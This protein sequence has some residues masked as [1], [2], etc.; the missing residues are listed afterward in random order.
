MSPPQTTADKDNDSNKL[1]DLSSFLAPAKIPLNFLIR[2]STSRE[3]WNSKGDI[4]RVEASDVGLP[5]DLSRILSYEPR[6]V[7]IINRLPDA[8]LKTSDQLYEVDE[9]IADLTRKRHAPDDQTRWKNWALI[10][11]YRSIPWKYLEP[12]SHDPTLAF[13]HLKHTLEA[14]QDGFPGLSNAAKIDLGLTLIES[15]RFSDMAWK[16]YAVNQAKRVSVGVENQY[17]ASRIA[18]AECVLNRIEGSMLRSAANLTPRSSE[19]TAPDVRMHCI[20]GQYAIQR[21]LNFMQ[22]EALESAE[23]V[24]ETWSPLNET[25]FPMEQAVN[26]R[27]T[28]IR[29]RSLRQRGELRD[30]IMQL[31]AGRRLKD[32]P[33]DIVLG[34]DLRDLICELADGLRDYNFTGAAEN[35]VRW[36]MERRRGSYIP[37][38]GKNL[39]ELSLAEVAFS[40]GQYYNSEMLCLGALKEF[41]RLKY[42]KMRAYIILAKVYHINSNFDQ[43][44][45][46]WMMAL[47]TIARF[48]TGCSRVTRMILR[49]LCHSAGNDERREQYQK[50][51][52]RLGPEDEADGVKFWIS[53]MPE[54]NKYL[55]AREAE[56]KES[57][58]K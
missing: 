25:P 3:R 9:E 1:L 33:G 6:L 56:A 14:C 36:E 51:L 46:Y 34:E 18:L 29:G 21:A 40:R 23:E 45:S 22:V 58:A 49:S 31:N 17:L 57:E 16:H 5:S 54:W 11:T 8:Y 13:P 30:S 27:K 37:A 47:E 39:L 4:E 19:E 20:A 53:G 15:S 43:A 42:E 32:E 26:Y 50:Q 7:S 24:L 12:L 44:H 35:V 38:I 28:I 2:G 52:E 48:T 10:V 55:Q 41:P